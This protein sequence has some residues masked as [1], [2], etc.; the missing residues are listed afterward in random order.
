MKRDWDLIRQVLEEVEAVPPEGRNRF[1][2]A[3][4]TADRIKIEHALLLVDRG[5]IEGT[6]VRPSADAPQLLRPALTWE[7]HEL[8]DTIR[9]KALWERIKTTARE[10][11]IELTFDAIKALAPL[12]LKALLG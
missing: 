8:L 4:P 5:Y 11:G 3:E 12:A 9:S 10:K 7:G 2:F 6:P 1:Q